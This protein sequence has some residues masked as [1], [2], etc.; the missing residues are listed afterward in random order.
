MNTMNKIEVRR[1]FFPIMDGGMWEHR[2]YTATVWSYP[3]NVA[4]VKCPEG[5]ATGVLM[6][7]IDDYRVGIPQLD[8]ALKVTGYTRKDIEEIVERNMNETHVE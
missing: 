6:A 4:P 3:D 8:E 7:Y 2:E 1:V 5:Y